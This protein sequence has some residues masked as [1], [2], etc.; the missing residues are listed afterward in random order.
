MV[1][2]APDDLV[3]EMFARAVL[4]RAPARPADSRHAG[5]GRRR[6]TSARCATIS[7]DAYVAP[8]L[9]VVGRRQS[10][11][12]ARC[13]TLVERAFGERAGRRRAPSTTAPAGGRRRSS[14]RA[15]GHRAEP[16]L[17]RHAGYPQAHDDRYASYV[18]NTDSRRLDELAA[19]PAHP[20]EA[21]AGLRGLQQPERL[22]RRRHAHAS[23]PAAPPSASA[24]S[25][26]SS[27]PSCAALQ[28]RR[29]C[30]P[31]SCAAPRI[32]SRAA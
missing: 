32:T 28:R 18:L 21:R 14:M 10:R 30:P 26:T 13:A 15:E 7:R 19:V 23:T 27:S 12:R 4:G 22:Q 25:S 5:D 29:R 1:E 9:I 31:T 20:R 17:P 24:R 8:N 16:R 6:S 11:A 3:H 2:D